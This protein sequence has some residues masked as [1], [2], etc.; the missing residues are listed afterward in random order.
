[1]IRTIVID[2][3]FAGV[4][5]AVSICP[6]CRVV[7]AADAAAWWTQLPEEQLA[8]LQ[9]A[10]EKATGNQDEIERALALAASDEQADLLWI[11]TG[12]RQ[13]DLLEARADALLDVVREARLTRGFFPDVT[14]DEEIYREGLLEPFISPYEHLNSWRRPL[15]LR[16]AELRGR[17]VPSTVA[18]VSAAVRETFA[19]RDVTAYFGPL[20]NP[21]ALMTTGWGSAYERDIMT[22]AVLRS[23]GVPARLSRLEPDAIDY[24]DGLDWRVIRLRDKVE[25]EIPPAGRGTVLVTL[26]R[27]GVPVAQADCFDFSQWQDGRWESLSDRDY[28]IDMEEIDNGFEVKIPA[29]KFLFTAG[30]RNANGDPFIQTR[31][32]QVTDGDTVTIDMDLD[33]P[34]E[35]WSRRDLVVRELAT[36][37][38]VSL[39]VGDGRLVPLRVLCADSP[40]V[41]VFHDPEGEPSRRMLTALQAL[42]DRLSAADVRTCLVRCSSSRSL[43]PGSAFTEILDLNGTYSN[44]FGLP[45]TGAGV[46]RLLPSVVFIQRGGEIRLWQEGFRQDIAALVEAQLDR[47][48]QKDEESISGLPTA[49]SESGA[50]EKEPEDTP[51]TSL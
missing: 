37:P 48:E 35:Q 3:M 10:L 1:M 51:T 36:L 2:L 12:A 26:R 11:I 49:E 50:G 4:F 22:V 27:A 21:L 18:A 38:D 20:P 25:E 42:A 9:E 14:A 5:L 44:A 28:P 31:V 41:L 23:L 16:H 29:G 19:I 30:T 7:S 40:I 17:D 45:K 33:I 47:F 34:L 46:V 32:L 13:L 15:R 24:H 6:Q 8:T 39:P 43:R